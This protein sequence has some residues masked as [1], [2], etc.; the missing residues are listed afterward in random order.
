MVFIKSRKKDDLGVG[1]LYCDGLVYTDNLDKANVL[2]HH[3]SPVYTTEFEDTSYL[4]SLTEHNIQAIESITTNIAGVADFFSNI[5]PFK[6]S[7]PDNIPAFLLNEIAFQIEPLLATSC[8][9]C[10]SFNARS[11]KSCKENAC[12]TCILLARPFTVYICMCVYIYGKI[13][14]IPLE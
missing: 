12:K 11:C 3:F 2:N 10:A 14:K 5:K 4:P 7:G 8:K 13:A 6:A 9:I 1:S